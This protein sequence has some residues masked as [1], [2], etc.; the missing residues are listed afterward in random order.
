MKFLL[1]RLYSPSGWK[2]KSAPVPNYVNL[3]WRY[4]LTGLIWTLPSLSLISL[5]NRNS[6]IAQT[7][8][9][10]CPVGTQPSRINLIPGNFEET[11]GRTFTTEGGEVSATFR[12]RETL[13]GRVIDRQESRITPGVYG[14]LP[15]PNLFWNIGPEKTP[16]PVGESATLTIEFN[17]SVTLASPLLI[18]DI[19]RDGERD[20]GFTYQDRVTITATNNGSPVNVTLRSLGTTTR[21]EGNRAVGINEN[22][23]PDRPD[24][25]ISVTPAG[26][27]SQIQ[28]LYEPGTE[29]GPPLQDESIGLQPISVCIPSP[30]GAIGDTV[31]NDLDGDGTQD[32]N[33][34]GLPGVTVRLIGAGEDNVFGTDDDIQLTTT[35][36]ENGK[37]QFRDLLAG[38]YRVSVPNPPN[39]FSPTQA[40]NEVLNLAP[41]QIFNDADFGFRRTVVEAEETPNIRVIKRITNALRNGQPLPVGNFNSF[42]PDGSSDNDDQLP[43]QERFVG[44]PRIETPLQSGDEIEY[45]IYF[46][47]EGGAAL[48]NTRFC[49]PI[50]TGTTF[51]NNSITV[52]GAG[53]DAQPPRYFTP[54][55][56]L[57][58]FADICGA[59]N[60][61]GAVVTN[62]GTISPNSF[63]FVR[64]RVRIN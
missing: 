53:S 28:I 33:E 36:D 17:Q 47:S 41:G 56:P 42:N 20:V 11:N 12:F 14:G 23:F 27:V 13:P 46:L 24:G 9:P 61:N 62:L 10:S 45:T 57:D 58:G 1:K 22:S 8:P 7:T 2:R 40:F 50:P 55:A 29:Y 52:S 16:A 26:P 60:T 39:R 32:A 38:Q 43:G 30:R 6:A 5:T 64:F 49:D 31:Y 15:G 4:T 51:I 63:G 21:I 18:L 35:T 3:L 34:P 37:Y 59:N 44:V 25:N 54:L 19:D 48:Q